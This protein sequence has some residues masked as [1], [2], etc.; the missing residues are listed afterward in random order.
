MNIKRWFLTATTV[1]LATF[2][3]SAVPSVHASEEKVTA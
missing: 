3:V 1:I 2:G